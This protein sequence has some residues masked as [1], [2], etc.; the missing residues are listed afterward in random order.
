[1]AEGDF[2]HPI[3]V[4]NDHRRDRAPLGLA[5]PALVISHAMVELK[6]MDLE[7][8]EVHQQGRFASCLAGPAGAELGLDAVEAA[9][10]VPVIVSLA[11]DRPVVR[12]PLVVPEPAMD[13]PDPVKRPG[14]LLACALIDVEPGRNR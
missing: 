12:F 3:L 5:P 14:S 13:I 7:Q 6:R 4:E 11:E 9:A 8:V 10:P 2:L 1:M